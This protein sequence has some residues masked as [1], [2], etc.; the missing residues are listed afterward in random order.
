MAKTLSSPRTS[1]LQ[2]FALLGSVELV[3]DTSQVTGSG[4]RLYAVFN[5][6]TVL[7]VG[8]GSAGRMKKVMR[9]SLAGKHNKSFICSMGEVI[10]ARKNTYAYVILPREAAAA[11]E[12]AVHAA[13]GVQTN[14][15]PA[16]WIPGIEARTMEEL[17][18]A[19]WERVQL[20][21]GFQKL[22]SVEK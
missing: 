18:V 17:H 13:M 12:S 21:P 8:K 19:I 5:G 14:R 4:Y 15:Q 3:S 9:G 6:D 11:A 22:D 1:V 2:H 20:A 10:F 7:Q 16:T